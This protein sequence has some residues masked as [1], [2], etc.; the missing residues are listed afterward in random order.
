[1]GELSLTYILK[2]SSLLKVTDLSN[3][4]QAPPTWTGAGQL[5]QGLE[6]GGTGRVGVLI[7]L[8]GREMEHETKVTRGVDK[9]LGCVEFSSSSSPPALPTLCW[10]PES[11]PASS[12]SF[13]FACCTSTPP[14]FWS[15][16]QTCPEQLSWSPPISPVRPLF[17]ILSIF[18]IKY[19]FRVLSIFWGLD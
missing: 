3:F 9:C 15:S 1:M 5:Q 6:V 11:F 16:S 12:L 19:I 13:S 2:R 17:S 4:L 10:S 14:R 8:R 7:H 18:F